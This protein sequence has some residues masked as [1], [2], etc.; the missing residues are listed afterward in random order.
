M[1]ETRSEK[2]SIRFTPTEML[3]IKMTA[4]AEKRS[5]SDMV[6]LLSL[7]AIIERERKI[8][9]DLIEKHDGDL[10]HKDVVKQN[11]RVDELLNNL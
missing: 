7:D 2:K 9:D 1:K 4:A 10:T 11:D 5:V 8:L 3:E 6:R